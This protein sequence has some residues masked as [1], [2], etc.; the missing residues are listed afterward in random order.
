MNAATSGEATHTS[1]S[2]VASLLL[3]LFLGPLGAIPAIILGHRALREIDA[4]PKT[5]GTAFAMFGLLIGYGVA[6]LTV[7]Y[8]SLIMF[9]KITGGA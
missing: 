4:N 9:V 5:K 2:A 7:L 1:H 8:L 3:S 6:V